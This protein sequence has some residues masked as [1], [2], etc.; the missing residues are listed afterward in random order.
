MYQR[1]YIGM[2]K[3]NMPSNEVCLI[4]KKNEHAVAVVDT[5]VGLTNNS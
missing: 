3:N 4:Y 5:P 1:L 2:G